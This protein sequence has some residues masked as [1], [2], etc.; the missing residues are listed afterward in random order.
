[1]VAIVTC[2]VVAWVSRGRKKGKDESGAL[3][4]AA[5]PAKVREQLPGTR[6]RVPLV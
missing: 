6:K 2:A 3:F 1:V 5:P 4:M